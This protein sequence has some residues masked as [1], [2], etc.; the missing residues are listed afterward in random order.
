MGKVSGKA[1]AHPHTGRH[2]MPRL[3]ESLE[4]W[5]ACSE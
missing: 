3:E 4:G 5:R 2:L 1:P